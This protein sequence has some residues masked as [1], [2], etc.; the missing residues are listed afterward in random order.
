M[1][2]TDVEDTDDIEFDSFEDDDEELDFEH[3]TPQDGAYRVTI[4][5]VLYSKDERADGDGFNLALRL[6][7]QLS[8]GDEF[9]GMQLSSYIWLGRDGTFTPAGRKQLKAL[10]EACGIPVGNTMR[11]SEFGAVPGTIGRNSGK[12]LSAF[13]GLSCGAEVKT[14]DEIING[15]ERSVCKPVAFYSLA[16]LAEIE[17]TKSEADF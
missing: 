10:A 8:T 3:L 15:E 12:I 2:V 6:Q 9:N 17:A 16:R 4:R 7:V 5:S 1:E 14:T 13:T 11:M